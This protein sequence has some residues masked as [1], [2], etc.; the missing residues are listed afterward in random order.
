VDYQPHALE[1][2]V[3]D[4]TEYGAFSEYRARVSLA[5]DDERNLLLSSTSIAS[6]S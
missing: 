5:D 6:T 4:V 3:A 1:L 2:K